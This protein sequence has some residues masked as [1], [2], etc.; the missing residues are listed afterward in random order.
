MER[1]DQICE[2]FSN[3]LLRL[4][5]RNYE[6]RPFYP[7][8]TARDVLWM[9]QQ[10]LEELFRIIIPTGGSGSDRDLVPELV[11]RVLRSLSTVLAVVFRIRVAGDVNILRQFLDLIILDNV[12]RHSPK[13]TDESLPISLTEAESV[14]R[15]FANEFFDTQFQFCAITLRREGD[16]VY[17][18]YRSQCPLPY[19]K[20]ERIGAGAFG[21]VYKVK[22]ERRH[23]RL[24]GDRTGNIE[25]EWIA[26]KD[27]KRHQSFT[28]E[29]DALKEIMEQPQKHDH[30]VMVLAILQYHDTNSLFFPL[31][32]CDL[33]QYLSGKH[34]GDRPG[35][36]TLEEKAIVYKRGIALAGA[37]AFLHG[38]SGGKVC[39]HLD[40]KPSNVLVFDAF[41]PEK[42]IWKITDFGLTRVRNNEYSSL[43]PGV[44]GIYLPPEC[45]T[46]HDR[47][48]THS[49]VWSFGCIFSL[50]IT[51]I[52]HGTRG[53][54]KFTLKRGEREEGD[55]F[56]IKPRNSTPR[57]APAVIAWFDHLRKSAAADEKESQMI[58]ES[59]DYLQ[60]KVLHPIRRQRASAKDVELSLKKIHSTFTQEAT[61]RSPTFPQDHPG[62]ASFPD[63]VL[64]WLKHRTSESTRSRLQSFH[65]NLG[66][67]GFGFRFSP[68]YGDYLAFFSPQRILVWTVSRIMAA[69]EHGSDIPEPQ[70]LQ[71]QDG[72]IRSYAVSSNAICNS[73]E[74]D[75]FQCVIYD[76]ETPSSSSRVGDGVRVSYDHMGSIKR[77]AMSSDGALTAFIITDRPRGS[78]SE[79]RIYLAYTQHL[80][81]T[82]EEG[83]TYS[84]PR[85]SHSNS[86]SDSS[87]MSITTAANLIF[88]RVS[89]GSAAQIRFLDFTPDGK[90]LVMVKQ[91][92]SRFSIKAWET[93]SGRCF[94]DFSV[95]IAEPW[96]FRNLF[97][98]C[99][100]FVTK[101]TEPCLAMVSDH[102][103]ILH[104]NLARR[105][106][107]DRRLNVD[108]DSMFV[109]DDGHTLVLIGKNNGL[110]TYLLPLQA[111]D[112]SKFIGV[113][114]I[115][116]LSY[117]PALDDAAVRRDANGHLKLLIASSSG[118]FFDMD[119]GA[120]R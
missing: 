38:G 74:G 31:A 63:R 96:A 68:A 72:T 62:H 45:A 8:G 77:V 93:Y 15:G 110:R 11:R 44:E 82:A 5:V 83:N 32:T 97:T 29:L 108:V 21:E 34:G 22:I 6:A 112:K 106:Y 36:M 4:R 13:L 58:R 60:S 37:L 89:V 35:P 69:L 117:T 25:P 99:C 88:D 81:D 9:N 50:V 14:F 119:V 46:P 55:Y 40:L 67:N 107:N 64:S 48:T 39:L 20:Q 49:D 7:N 66:T 30:L 86:V 57:V 100:L 1:I 71:I 3:R 80:M 109:C 73:L 16:I 104:V 52:L 113:A 118:A 61:P 51:Y 42:E 17:Q 24:T 103:R 33:Q 95:E 12:F 10:G 19:K 26:R 85:T 65:Y 84:I 75:S 43:A 98:T 23:L 116:R 79:C 87:L 28:V 114:K 92:G 27:F 120:E 105:T 91:E 115:N 70:L 41:H 102:R 90:F 2:D 47:V 101:A 54:T 53:V 111:L 94:K 76:V 78:E 59:L 18:D 56:Y